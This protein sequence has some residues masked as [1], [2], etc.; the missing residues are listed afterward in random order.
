MESGPSRFLSPARICLESACGNPFLGASCVGLF[1]VSLGDSLLSGFNAKGVHL[2]QVCIGT[3]PTRSSLCSL[4]SCRLLP[5]TSP[6][7]MSEKVMR[8]LAQSYCRCSCYC[9]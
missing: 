2:V 3:K 4:F 8:G 6:G 5:M 1:R 9:S 7:Y